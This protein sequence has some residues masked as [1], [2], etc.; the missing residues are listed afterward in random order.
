[1]DAFG[2]RA[3]TLPC[4]FPWEEYAAH[5]QR[6][7]QECNT[8]FSCLNVLFSLISLRE[9]KDGGA[10]RSRSGAEAEHVRQLPIP[11]ALA[12]L[13][14]EAQRKGSG[15]LGNRRWRPPHVLGDVLQQLALQKRKLKP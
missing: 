5:D 8:F 3:L 4:L 15:E 6:R 14:L 1:M 10:G 13:C 11:A 7:T 2:T 12:P 9:W